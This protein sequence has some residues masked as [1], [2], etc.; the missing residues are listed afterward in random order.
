MCCL[1]AHSDHSLENKTKMFGYKVHAV[2]TEFMLNLHSVTLN[3]NKVKQ[4]LIR[5]EP[6]PRPQNQN[7]G[8]RFKHLL[9][10]E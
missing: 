1:Q 4:E 7:I 6:K 10:I 8:N 5:S 3:L 9:L 2:D